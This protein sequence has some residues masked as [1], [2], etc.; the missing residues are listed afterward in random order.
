MIGRRDFLKLCAGVMLSLTAGCPLH[1]Y[2]A[3]TKH[4]IQTG[5][6]VLESLDFSVIKGKRVGLL[7]HPAA[8]IPSKTSSA[9]KRSTIQLLRK[10]PGVQ[11]TALFGAEHGLYGKAKAGE[12]VKD[13]KDPET[14]LPVY[15]LYGPGPTRKPT[16]AMLKNLDILIYDIQDTG[17]RSYTFVSSLG[18]AMEGCAECGKSF[19][20]LDRP[21]PLGGL[22]VEGN[23]LDPKYKSFVSQWNIPYVHGMTSG[24]MARM[25]NGENWI[26]KKC[27]LTV[28]KMRHWKREYTWLDLNRAWVPTSPNIPK[29]KTPLHYVSTGLAG[30][31][32][33]VNI[34]IRTDHPFETI[35]AAWIDADKLAKQMNAYKLPGVT[36]APYHYTIGKNNYHGVIVQFTKPATAPLMSINFYALEA[37]KKV[38]GRDLYQESVKRGKT[39]NLF[40]KLCGGT[41]IRNRLAKGV[42]AKEI[43]AAW[44]KDETQF[45]KDREKYLL[46]E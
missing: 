13:S 34:G 39:W 11:L 23:R 38:H 15:S 6:E 5:A 12:E 17:C 16:A 43:V 40:D 35:A 32:G 27:R 33:G 29:A 8:L 37:I 28:I 24:E 36:F 22:R 30:E 7:T 14:G 46:Y 18:L 21:N 9:Q 4:D 45:K 41:G 42:S 10:A 3:Q 1:S 20:V 44:K 25:I 19:M 26:S 31:A 2:A